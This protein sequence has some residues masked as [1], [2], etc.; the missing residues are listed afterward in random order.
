MMRVVWK[1]IIF[2]KPN[3]EKSFVVLL[4]HCEKI[5]SLLHLLKQVGFCFLV[6]KHTLHF[7]F[8]WDRQFNSGMI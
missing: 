7:F 5:C 2:V 8:P 4:Y 6:S 1:V 3:L